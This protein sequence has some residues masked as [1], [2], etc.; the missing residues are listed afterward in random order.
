MGMDYNDQDEEDD[1]FARL[2]DI[3]SFELD[4]NTSV[5]DLTGINQ[6][7]EEAIAPETGTS[8]DEERRDRNGHDR[9]GALFAER[10]KGDHRR[11]S[12]EAE[13]DGQSADPMNFYLKE[14][15]H[16]ALLS[17]E[18]ELKF[19]KIM[20]DGRQR[21]QDAVLQ[22]MVAIP[23]LKE[24]AREVEK[25]R[26]H[27][28]QAV[29]SVQADDSEAI[30]EGSREFLA[31]VAETLAL[32]EQRRALLSCFGTAAPGSDDPALCREVAAIG[33]KIA[34]IFN[35]L[36]LSSEYIN[37]VA[38]GM[39]E[40]SRRFRQMTL[41]VMYE[42]KSEGGARTPWQIE[43]WVNHLMLAESGIDM[44]GLSRLLDEVEAGREMT[45]QA[46]DELVRANL[47][48]VISVSKRFLN[49]GLQFSDLIQEGNIGLMRAVEKFD[50][51]RGCKFSTYATWWIRQS[52]TR[53]IA[54][55][56]RTIRLPVHLI[57]TINR[58][59][60][61]SKNFLIEEQRAPTPEEM[62]TALGM[63][64]EKVKAALKIAKDAI[65]LSTPVGN[66][67]ETS[68]GDFI[69]DTYYPDPQDAT[70]VTSL[71][72][73]L[74][75]VLSSLTPKEAKVLRMRYGID[76]KYDH[77]LEEVGRC[78]TV[79]R[80]RIRQIEAQAILKLKHPSRVGELRVFMAD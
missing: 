7:D 49:R 35:H 66:D 6:R 64:V 18:E 30:A 67:G 56:G 4:E 14:M 32:D 27:I 79:T 41:Q 15:G 80:E 76:M 25:N 17:Q 40:L 39:E 37:A 74:K 28:C 52:I 59:L 70:I 10:R 43:E 68:L 29:P 20:E 13:D 38:T 72:D 61:V 45:R 60:R 19:A 57:E 9:R 47:R 16:M 51:H 21:T 48:L 31:K 54:D 24:L 53:S 62:A 34:A 26:E 8:C 75:R 73:C 12:R 46:K 69:E 11:S 44:K 63:E 36:L 2:G 78:F 5:Y 33:E 22:T 23:A 3:D 58:L 71:R 77:T 55:Q 42:A 1:K 65:S 50:Y